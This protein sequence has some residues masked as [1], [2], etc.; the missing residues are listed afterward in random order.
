MALLKSGVDLSTISQWLGHVSP[1]TTNRYATLDL[2]MKS[3]AIN[4]VKPVT[5]SRKASWRTNETVLQWL[6]SL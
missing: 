4:R 2:D 6:E 5:G 3:E 1:T